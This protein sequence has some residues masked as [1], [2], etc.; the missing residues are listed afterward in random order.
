MEHTDEIEE[1]KREAERSNVLTFQRGDTMAAPKDNDKPL[2][3]DPQ[4]DRALQKASFAI[5]YLED[6]IDE[7]YARL[8]QARG[9]E[10]TRLAN[11]LS[12]AATALFH[13]HRTLSALTGGAT[14]MEEALREL[15][16][17]D[18]HED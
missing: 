14:P 9:A 1:R 12:R 6:A 11:A 18:F 4:T 2:A 8:L 13:A 5:P 3:H 15:E 17:L 16:A 10:F 7:I